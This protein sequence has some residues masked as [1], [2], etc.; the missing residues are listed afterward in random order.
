MLGWLM[1]YRSGARHAP[2]GRVAPAG[3]ARLGS[4]ASQPA[5][6]SARSAKHF[7]QVTN[8]GRFTEA[9]SQSGAGDAAGC[10]TRLYSTERLTA[11]RGWPGSTPRV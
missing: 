1:C 8:V 2:Q 5:V 4:G 9:G 10:A 3:R 7:D 6:V 11:F